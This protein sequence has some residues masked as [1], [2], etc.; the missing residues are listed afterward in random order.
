MTLAV[1]QSASVSV[2]PTSFYVLM[3]VFFVNVSS[4]C[5]TIELRVIMGLIQRNP[6][7]DFIHRFLIF[8]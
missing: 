7:T 1:S 2:C 3:V 5:Q 8:F 4:V 6:K